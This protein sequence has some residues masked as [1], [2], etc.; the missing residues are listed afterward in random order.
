MK[1][2]FEEKAEWEVG[3]V[4]VFTS[5][6]LFFPLL[7][8][9]FNTLRNEKAISKRKKKRKERDQVLPPPKKTVEPFL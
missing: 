9:R 1:Q 6:C 8:R 7:N 4:K 3:Q 5:I 2:I